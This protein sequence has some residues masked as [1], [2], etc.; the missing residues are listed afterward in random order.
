MKKLLITML[1]G[2]DIIVL[3]PALTFGMMHEFFDKLL[4][5]LKPGALNQEHP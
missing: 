2:L 5:K 1:T 3:L 4:Y